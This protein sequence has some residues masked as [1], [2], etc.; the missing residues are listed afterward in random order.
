LGRRL[1]TVTA[2]HT[3]HLSVRARRG[4]GVSLAIRKLAGIAWATTVLSFYR[5]SLLTASESH[6][7]PTGPGAG[8]ARLLSCEPRSSGG[9]LCGRGSRRR[10]G[11]A[12]LSDTMAGSLLF[13]LYNFL[14]VKEHLER[15]LGRPVD[16]ATHDA[17]KRQSRDAI[18][19]EAVYAAWIVPR[20]DR[21][22]PGGHRRH[23][24]LCGRTGDAALR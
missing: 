22:S 12:S 16:F 17:L 6:R 10:R 21:G 9:R 5:V 13:R 4:G 2:W 23:S 18:L 11:R 14:A 20:P 1:F 8:G 19:C 3:A 7:S 15:L 24:S